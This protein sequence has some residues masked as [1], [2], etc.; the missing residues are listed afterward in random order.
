[1]QQ[2]IP[3]GQYFFFHFYIW[4]FVEIF[5]TS[6]QLGLNSDKYIQILLLLLLLLVIRAQN[7]G[8]GCT[9]AIRLIVHPVF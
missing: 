2:L 1:M 3:K 6:Y 7:Q 8:S 4:N 9:A 5:L